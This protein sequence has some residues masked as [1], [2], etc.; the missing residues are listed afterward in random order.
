MVAD[1]PV[2]SKTLK[3]EKYDNK[4]IKKFIGKSNLNFY[5]IYPVADV[6][7][8]VENEKVPEFYSA[9][10]KFFT[11]IY[12]LCVEYL[13]QNAYLAFFMTYFGQEIKDYEIENADFRVN[14]F[15][16]RY[17]SF[18]FNTIYRLML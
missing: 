14:N 4:A 2:K 11:D 16:D 7:K 17:L 10:S 9:T 12:E 3:L 15:L 8:T 1:K 6:E 5:G 18:E 13:K